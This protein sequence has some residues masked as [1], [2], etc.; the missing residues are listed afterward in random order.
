MSAPKSHPL[1]LHPPYPGMHKNTD[2][3]YTFLDALFQRTGGSVSATVNLKGLEASVPELNTLVGIDTR[4]T[5]QKQL[6][7]KAQKSELGT[8]ATQNKDAVDITGGT[9]AGTSISGSDIKVQAGTASNFLN[10]GGILQSDNSTVGNG[11]GV[12]TTLISYSMLANTLAAAKSFI[13]IEAFGTF[14]ANANNKELKLKLGTTTL[15]ASGSI[16][17]N[18]GSWSI[19]AKIIRNSASSQKSIVSIISDNSLVLDD[20][21][22]IAVTE[23]L[24]TDLAIF[25]TGNGVGANDV[26]QEGLIIKWFK[27]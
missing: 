1:I 6:D 13:E 10:I 16:A 26:V 3:M 22:Y 14:A 5:V 18:S 8:I 20:A 11:A 27:L 15:Y 12:E 2:D 7:L 24:T 4:N 21:K 9:I 23:D 25:C 19:K 17:A